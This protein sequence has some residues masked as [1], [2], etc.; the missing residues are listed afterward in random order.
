MFVAGSDFLTSR[1]GLRGTA[2]LIPARIFMYSLKQG[3]ELARCSPIDGSAS[4]GCSA[5]RAR[6]EWG[7][8]SALCQGRLRKG[9][10][11]LPAHCWRY[12]AI[13]LKTLV[14]W[15]VKARLMYNAACRILEV[16]QCADGLQCSS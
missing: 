5:I 16:G 11:S 9:M 3:E 6:S 2:R 4:L 10:T 13:T 15:W 7:G 14:A 12:I 8:R 1:I